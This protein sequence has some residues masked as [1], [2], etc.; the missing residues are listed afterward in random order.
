MYYA[1][2]GIIMEDIIAIHIENEF[3]MDT[4]SLSNVR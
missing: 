2:K 1:P 4:S 3:F